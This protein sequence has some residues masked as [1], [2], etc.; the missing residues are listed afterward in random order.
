MSTDLSAT[1]SADAS[2][3]KSTLGSMR[4]SVAMYREW[5]TGSNRLTTP[6][7]TL[8]TRASSGR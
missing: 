2:E 3:A 8:I 7:P 5:Q 1:G 6:H 4:R